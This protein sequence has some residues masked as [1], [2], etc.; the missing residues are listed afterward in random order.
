MVIELKYIKEHIKN[1]N[2]ILFSIF[3]IMLVLLVIKL[4]KPINKEFNKT[5]YYMDTYI[6]VTIYS[7]NEPTEVF[8]KIDNLYK[9]YDKLADK[10]E[11]YNN[12]LYYIN[13]TNEEVTI[14][15]KLSNLI[16]YGIDLYSQ[17]NGL[18]NI[19][20]GCVT[21]IWKNYRE[22]GNGVPSYEELNV[23]DTNIN[24]IVL[25]NNK[26]SGNFNIDLGGIAKGYVTQLAGELLNS[27]GYEYYIIN[28]GGNVLA[29]TKNNQPFKIG[30]Q[31]PIEA[32]KLLGVI[33]VTNKSV[34][35][36]GG[37]ER[38]YEYDGKFYNHIINPKTLYP[39]D[40]M[41]SVSVITN[42]STLGDSLSTILFLMPI[43]DGE[44]FIK[45]YNVDVIW[46]DN[47]N[48]IITTEGINLSE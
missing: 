39:S 13:N 1:I 5:M 18:F 30:I 44:K 25:N 10:Y 17:S 37:Y 32:N 28:A 14:D 23:C 21:D 3:I 8:E 45:D 38:Y 15:E 9:E 6:K 4:T 24:N 35:T 27:N 2:T 47:D 11:E 42:S 22:Q 48:N 20:I 31:S 41:K 16:K 12:N 7:K 33:E 43:E 26:I 36:S 40:Y 29:T 46:V 19:N 34:V